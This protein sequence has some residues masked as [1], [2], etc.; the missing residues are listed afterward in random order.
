[1]PSVIAVVALVFAMLGGAYAASGGLTAKQKKEVK[2]IAKSFQGTGPAG[3]AGPAGAA[4][5]AGPAGAKGDKGDTGSAGGTGPAGKSVVIGETA[6][7]CGVPNGKTI[8]VAGEPATKQNICNGQEGEEGSPW[9]AGG[10]LPHEK[11]EAGAW[12]ISS[13]GANFFSFRVAVA[14]LS[15]PLPLPAELDGAHVYVVLANGNTG[16]GTGDLENGSA[17]VKNLTTTGGAF[18]VGAPIT[19]TGIPP[20]TT[21]VANSGGTLTL[22]ANATATE[23]G[24]ALTAGLPAAC[25]NGEGTSPSV[26]NPE[27]DPGYLCA[28][29]GKVAGAKAEPA[30]AVGTLSAFGSAGADASGAVLSISPEEISPGE[31]KPVLAWGSFAV[32]AP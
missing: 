22:S 14:G 6:P 15:F 26:H 29:I 27:A 5:P 2:A 32:T 17:E 21:V 30:P 8:E 16:E 10:V 1:M 13:S 31:F 23:V 7:G 18:K 28:F 24:V 3:P 11:T 4:G 19:A 9:T 20:G 25:D 12:A